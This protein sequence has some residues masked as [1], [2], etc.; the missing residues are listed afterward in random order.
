MREYWS[1][2]SGHGFA[3][4]EARVELEGH[5]DVCDP[6]TKFEAEA[7]GD[8]ESYIDEVCMLVSG[9]CDP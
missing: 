6:R 5:F 1:L 8:M 9:D 4:C 2:G 3:V 7:G